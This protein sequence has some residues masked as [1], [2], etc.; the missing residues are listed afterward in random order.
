MSGFLLISN[1]TFFTF[2]LLDLSI[3]FFYQYPAEKHR[4]MISFFQPKL[5]KF[6]L[7]IS[8]RS[9]LENLYLLM[10]QFDSLLRRGYERG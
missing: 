6:K 3:V 4:G 5:S 8:N 1:V 7:L 2:L 9:H 10:G